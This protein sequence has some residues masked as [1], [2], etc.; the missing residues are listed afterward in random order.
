MTDLEMGSST[1]RAKTQSILGSATR[2]TFKIGQAATLAVSG[3]LL[4]VVGAVLAYGTTTKLRDF[5]YSEG[6]QARGY[7]DVPGFTTACT[8][9][10]NYSHIKLGYPEQ[11]SKFCESLSEKPFAE[12]E[13]IY[14]PA[15]LAA[16]LGASSLSLIT[17]LYATLGGVSLVVK[18][19]EVFSSIL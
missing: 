12:Q 3:V 16:T 13:G 7:A 17:S 8:K 6:D 5:Y 15:A 11:D 9:I 18:S 10:T 4:T 1:N 2:G 14:G 19:V